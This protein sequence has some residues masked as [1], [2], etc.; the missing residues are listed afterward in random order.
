MGHKELEYR[1]ENHSQLMLV[2]GRRG[3]LRV[4]RRRQLLR[5]MP[6]FDYIYRKIYEFFGLDKA[7]AGFLRLGFLI[8]VGLEF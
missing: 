3:R 8:V 2:L 5:E 7:I 4:K 1:F 6:V